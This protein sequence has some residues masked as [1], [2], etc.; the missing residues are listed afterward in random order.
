[1]YDVLTDAVET[2]YVTYDEVL[3]LMPYELVS[4]MKGRQA[5]E[6]RE[7]NRCRLF[8]GSILATY[9]NFN[10]DRRAKKYNWDEIFRSSPKVE[11]EMSD[12]EIERRF[13]AFEKL[14][15]D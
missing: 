8:F 10:T 7:V 5:I 14:F 2:G 9:I 12:E 4:L 11:P 15:G 1:M 13:E 3:D 6:E